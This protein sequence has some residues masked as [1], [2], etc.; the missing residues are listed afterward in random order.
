[1]TGNKEIAQLLIDSTVKVNARTVN[2][3]T[4][5]HY[6]SLEGHKDFM[7]FII[8]HEA[9]K[10]IV[11][12]DGLS[13]L[14]YAIAMNQTEVAQLLLDSGVVITGFADND[15][16]VLHVASAV[17][18]PK[19]NKGLVDYKGGTELINLKDQ[20]LSWAPIH[21]AKLAKNTAVIDLLKEN[22]ALDTTPIFSSDGAKAL[23]EAFK[24]T[25]VIPKKL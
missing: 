16:S 12:N 14:H 9:D 7:S 10:Q 17:G 19:M 25:W 6:A 21:F 8:D 13:A 11:N 15:Y 5:L 2:G 1:M 20:V 4:A 23:V 24:I 3:D 22:G 18:D